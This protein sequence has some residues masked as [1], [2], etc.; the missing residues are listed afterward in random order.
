M[1][2]AGFD[3]I[4]IDLQHGLIDYSQAV[5]M[6]QSLAG[7]PTPAFVRPSD[8]D[9]SGIMKVLDAGAVGVIVPMVESAKEA[10]AIVQACRYPPDGIRSWGPIR[11]SL[12]SKEFS[13]EAANREVICVVMVET[14]TAI[15]NLDQILAVP[16][17]DAV[18]V[19]TN[20]LALSSGEKAAF[21][22]DPRARME[23]VRTVQLT[24]KKRGVVSGIAAG[25]TETALRWLE[26]GFEMLALPSD[27]AILTQGAQANV[28][29]LRKAA[30]HH[31][32]SQEA[33]N[34]VEV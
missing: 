3:W 1:G 14:P 29:A 6:L 18:F 11:A 34:A 10:A 19:G 26:A 23:L 31:D 12:Y 4:C 30:G 22:G 5:H 25:D 9:P 16:G 28:K 13:P 7:T 15:S 33:G 17:I 20:D 24:C 21:A 8:S 32:D 2:R 27:V